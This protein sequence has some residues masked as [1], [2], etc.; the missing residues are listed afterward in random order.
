MNTLRSPV[1]VRDVGTRRSGQAMARAVVPWLALF[2][3]FK[4]AVV[5]SLI[6]PLWDTPDESGHYS[7]VMEVA[8]GKMPKLG[9]SVIPDEVMQSWRGR[10]GVQGNW[11]AQHPPLYY[12]VASIFYKGANYFGFDFEEKVRFTRL[13][14]AMFSALAIAALVYLLLELSGRPLISVSA[15]ILLAAVPMYWH[16][17]SGVSHDSAT[18][19]FAAVSALF[20]I[21]Y[22]RSLNL[23]WAVFSGITIGLGFLTKVTS[24]V[25]LGP[26]AGMLILWAFTKGGTWRSRLVGM[27]VISTAFA[28]LP[29]VWMAYNYHRYG[30]LLPDAGMLA[31]ATEPGAAISPWA[32]VTNYPFWQHTIINFFGLFG[33]QGRGASGDNWFQMS[34]SAIRLFSLPLLASVMFVFSFRNRIAIRTEEKLGIWSIA[35]IAMSLAVVFLVPPGRYI[36]A[37][38]VVLAAGFLFYFFSGILLRPLKYKQEYILWAFSGIFLLYS[39][40]YFFTLWASFEG[41]LRATHGRYF[42]P[43]L[44]FGIA[45]LLSRIPRSLEKISVIFAIALMFASDC[46]LYYTV[47][48]FYVT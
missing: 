11:I 22:I 33:W 26:L 28:V 48:Q 7:Y 31:P 27:G 43:V 15:G 38:C 40:V 21:R 34:D 30:A 37:L 32:Y 35:I 42:Y 10:S 17:S 23:R 12:A 36:P 9:E 20:A 6:T 24:L 5:A 29:M 4:F 45:V 39:V 14:T 8:E 1:E 44:A 13:A 41:A 2:L 19:F 3:F 18:L 47:E 25:V 16:M 46:Y